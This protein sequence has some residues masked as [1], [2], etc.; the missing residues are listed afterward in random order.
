MIEIKH[1]GSTLFC[2]TLFLLLFP[3][4]LII[5]VSVMVKLKLKWTEKKLLRLP[6]YSFAIHPLNSLNFFFSVKGLCYSS[7]SCKPLYITG[8]NNILKVKDQK[9]SPNL[10]EWVPSEEYNILLLLG[11]SHSLHLAGKWSSLIKIV[12]PSSVL[13]NGFVKLGSG[14]KG[15]AYCL[16]FLDEP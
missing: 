10:K 4:R 14:N 11:E 8:G 9:V 13:Y 1:I 6:W 3:C 16:L 5:S 2:H 12:H 15:R 7:I